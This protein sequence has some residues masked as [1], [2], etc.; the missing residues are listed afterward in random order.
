MPME[1]IDFLMQPSPERI[2]KEIQNICDSYSHPWDILAELSQN[3]V[4]AIR[5][6]ASKKAL[7]DHTISIKLDARDRSIEFYDSGIGLPGDKVVDL[8]AP[9]GTNKTD[10]GLDRKSVV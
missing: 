5:A 10:E 6:A 4:D 9:H 1:P 8:L 7:L 2:K 3:S